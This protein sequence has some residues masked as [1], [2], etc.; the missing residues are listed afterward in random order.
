LSGSNLHRHP[1]AGLTPFGDCRGR[2][3]EQFLAIQGNGGGLQGAPPLYSGGEDIP[4]WGWQGG[5][6]RQGHQRLDGRAHYQEENDGTAKEISPG[7]TEE[8]REQDV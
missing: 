2:N 3:S 7:F 5:K 4:V 8:A 1:F 6:L